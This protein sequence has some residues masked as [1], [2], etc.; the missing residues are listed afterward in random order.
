MR[1][2]IKVSLSSDTRLNDLIFVALD[3]ALD[4]IRDSGRSLTP[5]ALTENAWGKRTLTRFPE[6]R[7]SAA[8]IAGKNKISQERE[9][10]ARYAFAWDGYVTVEGKT[11][12]ALLIEAGG[13]IP[14]SG[15][16]ACQRYQRRGIFRK[17]FE[18][19]GPFSKIETPPSRIAVGAV[20]S[21]KPGSRGLLV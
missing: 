11:W 5:F 7:L 21:S 6:E 14:K 16:I 18:V 19:V 4:V 13:R 1:A 3:E 12:D 10:L 2:G 9:N 15:L 8:E 17:G 20:F